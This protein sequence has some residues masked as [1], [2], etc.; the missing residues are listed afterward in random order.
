MDKMLISLC[1]PFGAKSFFMKMFRE[2]VPMEHFYTV[3]NM[4]SEE[5][6]DYI[7]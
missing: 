5:Y 4:S 1:S 7:Q 2:G 6:L 3:D